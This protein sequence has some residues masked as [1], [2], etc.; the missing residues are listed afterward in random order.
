MQGIR[1]DD[2]P[3]QGPRSRA[4]VMQPDT[5]SRRTPA[6]FDIVLRER[7]FLILLTLAFFVAGAVYPYPHLAAWVGFLFASYSAVANDSIQTIGTFIASNRSKRWWILWLFIGGIFIATTAYSWFIYDGDV[8]YQRLA[9]KGFDKTPTSFS[10]LQI[11]APLFLLILTRLRM[12]VSTTFLLLSSFA[13]TPGS[14]GKVLGKSLT[15]Y[16]L[17]FVIALLVWGLVMRLLRAWPRKG[18]AHPMWRVGQ[19]CTTGFLWSVWLMQDAANIAVYLPRTLSGLE[20]AAF[21]SIVFGGLGLL[22]YFGGEKVQQVVD[23]K[24]DVVDVRAATI[25]DLVYAGILYY[26]KVMSNVPMSTTWV[27]IGLLAGRELGM[28]WTRS[29]AR[30]MK[31]SL[32]LMAKDLAYVTIGL[33]ISLILAFVVNQSFQTKILATLG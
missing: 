29:S 15:G 26:F 7:S 19:W 11:A 32:G 1:D 13:T 20:Y 28:S 9:A 12:P 4:P 10:F 21:A 5:A 30:G 17:A 18:K 27:F 14:I 8:S 24:S 23:E 2:G 16:V 33:V 22:F 6:F 31:A 3:G 25:I